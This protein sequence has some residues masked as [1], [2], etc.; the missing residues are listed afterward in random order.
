MSLVF[1]D[2][3]SAYDAVVRQF[4]LP[5]H[6]ITPEFLNT[7]EATGLDR[8]AASRIVSYIHQHPNSLI[9]SDIPAHLKATLRTWL[10]TPWLCT[11]SAAQEMT[12]S[13]L[14]HNHVDSHN[15]SLPSVHS[16]PQQPSLTTRTGV[17]QGDPLSTL[18]FTTVFTV[19]LDMMHHKLHQ[20]TTADGPFI[21]LPLP[22]DR[23][24]SSTTYT[25]AEFHRVCFADDLTIPI[26][27]TTPEE[28]VFATIGVMRAITQTFKDAGMEINLASGKSEVVLKLAGT[29][30]KG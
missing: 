8:D 13:H 28:A 14:V 11:R 21:K 20:I 16:H 1:I 27:T 3:K 29:R 22:A 26:S 10:H 30:G 17:L 24:L 6:N 19:L 2:I 4:V 15:L 9:N 5:P 18:L 12:D 7:L 25:Q 23:T